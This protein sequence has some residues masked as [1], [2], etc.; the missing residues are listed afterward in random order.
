[1]GDVVSSKE[2][3]LKIRMLR[4]QAGLSQEKLAEMVSVSAQQLQKYENSQTTLNVTKLQLIAVALKVPVTVFFSGEAT[5]QHVRL[6]DEEEGLLQ[7]YRRIK[8]QELRG[9]ILKLVGNLNKRV[10]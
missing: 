7:A 6:T 8:N 10:K 3:G 2:I 9:C 4:Q 1:M 5:E